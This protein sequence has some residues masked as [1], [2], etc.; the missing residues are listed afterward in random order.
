[1]STRIAGR[2]SSGDTRD[3][4]V[5]DEGRVRTTG[6]GPGGE[7][8]GDPTVVGG[9]DS[10]GDAQALA[11]D[12]DGRPILGESNEHVGQVGGHITNPTAS[13]V[14]PADTNQYAVGDLMAN[15]TAAGSVVPMQFDCSRIPAGSFYVHG[16]RCRKSGTG[17]TASAFRLHLF[18]TEPTVANGDNGAFS[19]S[20]SAGYIGAIDV[21][22]NRAFSD[23][24]AGG[25]EPFSRRVFAVKLTA[26]TIIYALQEANNTYTP[27]SAEQFDWTLEVTP[28]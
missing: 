21:A 13:F 8:A 10:N 24:A 5:D 22:V 11:V 14:R 26:G 23:G 16:A 4:A 17:T 20:A 6:Q 18:L 12:S 1:M 7:P 28:N 25:G 27:A 3:I 19:A 9:V 2:T 15:S